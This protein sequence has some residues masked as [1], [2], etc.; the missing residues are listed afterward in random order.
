MIDRSPPGAWRAVLDPAGSAWA[1]CRQNVCAHSDLE[2]QGL[3]PPLDN[4]ERFASKLLT[5]GVENPFRFRLP[6]PVDGEPS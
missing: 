5:G 3:V 4:D 1:V 2:F 6:D